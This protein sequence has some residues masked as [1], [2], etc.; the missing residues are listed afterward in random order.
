MTLV[1]ETKRTVLQPGTQ[2]HVMDAVLL[3]IRHPPQVIF[4]TLI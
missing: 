1:L 4:S 3:L 2:D